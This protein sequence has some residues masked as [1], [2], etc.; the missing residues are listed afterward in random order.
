MGLRIGEQ[1]DIETT[2]AIS[3]AIADTA[4]D[5]NDC[6]RVLKITD[7]IPTT[8]AELN[9]DNQK[10]GIFSMSVIPYTD[11]TAWLY[12]KVYDLALSANDEAYKF[13]PLDMVEHIVYMDYYVGCYLGWHIDL[14]QEAPHVGRKLTMIVNLNNS[15]DYRG[16]DLQIMSSDAVDTTRSKGCCIFYP[17]YLRSKISPVTKGNKKILIAWFGGTNLK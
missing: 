1:I 10:L 12:G 8:V 15:D 11:D 14:G 5:K 3:P 2:L 13:D 4:F 6:E 7:E 16:G 17:S 9:F